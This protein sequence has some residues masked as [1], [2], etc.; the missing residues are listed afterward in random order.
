MQQRTDHDDHPP[1]SM[2]IASGG[3]LREDAGAQTT[4]DPN[5]GKAQAEVAKVQRKAKQMANGHRLKPKPK[6]RSRRPMRKPG[7]QDPGE[8]G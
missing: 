2:G 1:R 8:V 7:G 5:A 4:P 6:C 3:C